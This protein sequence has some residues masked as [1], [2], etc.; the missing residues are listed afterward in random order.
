M[1]E[2]KL[3]NALRIFICQKEYLLYGSLTNKSALT[4]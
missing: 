3:V 2:K 1:K 4:D